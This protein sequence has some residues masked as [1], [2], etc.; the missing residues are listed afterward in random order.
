MFWEQTDFCSTKEA[1]GIEREQIQKQKKTGSDVK[2]MQLFQVVKNS[3]TCTKK[4]VIFFPHIHKILSNWNA[5][6][7]PP[8]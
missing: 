8:P 2:T 3:S 1:C 4:E 5:K 7:N 6:S